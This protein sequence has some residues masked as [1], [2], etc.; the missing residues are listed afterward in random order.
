M[1][2]GFS[3]SMTS[4]NM[5]LPFGAKTLFCAAVRYDQVG[6]VAIGEH[7]ST[8]KAVEVYLPMFLTV[9]ET[10]SDSLENTDSEDFEEDNL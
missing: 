8:C 6:L 5:T 10:S 3:S 2:S 1:I 7:M 4:S 9:C